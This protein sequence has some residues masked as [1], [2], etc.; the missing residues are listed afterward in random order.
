MGKT[1]SFFTNSC[2]DA[3]FFRNSRFPGTPDLPIGCLTLRRSPLTRCDICT[4]GSNAGANASTPQA[5]A[6]MHL[7]ALLRRCLR[8][9]GKQAGHVAL[10]PSGQPCRRLLLQRRKVAQLCQHP[11]AGLLERVAG[12]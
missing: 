2:Y 3:Y 11:A 1:W 9:Q 8:W 10:Y 5:R 7:E 6:R 12:L 4:A